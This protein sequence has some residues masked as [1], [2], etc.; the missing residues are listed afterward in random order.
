[1]ARAFHIGIAGSG[2]IGR[3]LAVALDSHEDLALS[4]IL[5]RREIKSIRDF[6]NPDK[7]TNSLQELIDRSD[8][9]VECTGDVIHATDVV[10]QSLLAG[11]PVVTMNA[12]FHI[13]TGSYFVGRGVL[14]EAEGDQPGCIAALAE[15]AREMG[16]TPIVYGNRK[17]YYHPSPPINEMQFWARK[18]GISLE[19][20]TSF[21]DGTKIQIEAALV[22]N[23]LGAQIA[24][25]GLLR[26]EAE[27]LQSGGLA[28][29]RHAER[30]GSPISDYV[31]A[32][33]APAG[34]FIVA[35]CERHQHAALEYLKLGSGPYYVLVRNYHL[36]HL[37]IPK[38]IRR[39]LKDGQP[40]LTNST[41]PTVSVAAIAKRSLATGEKIRRGIGSFSLR[42]IA[43]SLADHPN[44]IPI[45][46]VSD[47]LVVR[48]VEE[49][50][51][52]SFDD[53]L[54][55]DTSALRAWN[56]IVGRLISGER[57]H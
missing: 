54:I 46:L 7:L 44:H 45:G 36:C 19:Q 3:G 26:L 55:P 56:E 34:V 47:A 37:E 25:D 9:I 10:D 52:L 31:I 21:T 5:T 22:A 2:F 6:P 27:N 39:L 14:T 23:G 20:V 4:A 8:L 32:P 11:R 42:G 50:Q 49:G 53:V 13:T 28:L 35:T 24:R 1:M 43:V 15:E 12:E 30:L 51:Q 38:T 16:F 29:A 18:Q 41:K 40:L 57:R 17:G 33:K 48:P